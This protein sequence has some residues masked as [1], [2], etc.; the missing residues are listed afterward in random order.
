LKSPGPEVVF[1]ENPIFPPKW[2]ILDITHF[3]KNRETTKKVED[4]FQLPGAFPKMAEMKKIF[5]LPGTFF[6]RIPYTL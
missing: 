2:P 5:S 1:P 4:S 6:M 3:L